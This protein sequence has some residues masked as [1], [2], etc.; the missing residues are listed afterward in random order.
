MTP[1]IA[2]DGLG[3]HLWH[4]RSCNLV[5]CYLT[6]IIITDI[7]ARQRNRCFAEIGPHRQY[8]MCIVL[9]VCMHLCVCACSCV[10]SY[11]CVCVSVWMG[12]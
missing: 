10:C 4:D 2:V 12:E 8:G 6:D 3:D 1:K 7:T 11:T 5:I 9:C